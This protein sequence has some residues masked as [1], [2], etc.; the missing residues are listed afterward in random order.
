MNLFGRQRPGYEL[1]RRH[2]LVF[3]SPWNLDSLFLSR[4]ESVNHIG[5]LFFLRINKYKCP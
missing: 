1:H 4:D 2:L 5:R 3:T